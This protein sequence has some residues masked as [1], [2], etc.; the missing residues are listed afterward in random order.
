LGIRATGVGF[1]PREGRAD[2]RV[3]TKKKNILRVWSLGVRAERREF[4][5]C[6]ERITKDH[7]ALTWVLRFHIQGLGFRAEVLASEFG[8]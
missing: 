6:V 5:M 1:G 2:T 3:K 8:D 4:G 7:P